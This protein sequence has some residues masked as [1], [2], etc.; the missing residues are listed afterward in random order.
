NPSIDQYLSVH[1]DSFGYPPTNRLLE[2]AAVVDWTK[3]MKFKAS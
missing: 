1:E 2:E 3:M